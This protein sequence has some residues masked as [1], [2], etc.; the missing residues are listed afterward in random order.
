MDERF[1]SWVAMASHYIGE[2]FDHCKPI[3]DKDFPNMHPMIRFVSTQLYLSCHFSSESSLILLQHGQE[4]DAEIINRSIIEGVTK[5]IYMLNGSEEEVLKKVNEYWAILPSYSAIKR[6]DRASSLLAEVEPQEMHNWLSIQELTL[7]PEQVD[8][9]RGDTNKQQR[10]QLEQKWSFSHIIQEFSESND[11]RLNPLIHLG[12]NYG[13]SSHL[14]HKDGDGVG[15]VWERCV[16]NTEEQAWVKSAHIARSISDLCTFAEMRSLFLFQFCGEK[17]AFSETLRQN[18]EPLFAG[19]KG[20]LQEFN[21][22]E[23]KT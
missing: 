22:K 12:Y 5:Y 7:E 21:S 18:Y 3:L 15:M 2:H 4:W 19:L 20:A 6:S 23:Y 13:M 8:S 16:R 11:K 1:Q 9:I 10:K 14:I 17:P